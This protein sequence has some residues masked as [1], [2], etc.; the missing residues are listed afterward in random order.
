MSS[1]F[2]C[3]ERL[4]AQVKKP[5]AGSNG[6]DYYERWLVVLERLFA[7][8]GFATHAEVDGVANT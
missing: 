7:D 5:D 6:S 1:L 2:T 4:S 8:K 3:A